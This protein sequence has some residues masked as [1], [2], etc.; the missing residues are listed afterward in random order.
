MPERRSIRNHWSPR[1]AM[2]HSEVITEIRP[3]PAGQGGAVGA[4][5]PRPRG[6][7]SVAGRSRSGTGK[8][9]LELQEAGLE[10]PV[11]D[12]G[13]DPGQCELV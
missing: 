1:Y 5:A 13:R 4:P 2:T 3:G 7:I 9:R 10:K 6:R 8:A 11:A 12:L